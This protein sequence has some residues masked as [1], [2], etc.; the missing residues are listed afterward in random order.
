VRKKDGH[1]AAAAMTAKWLPIL[2]TGIGWFEIMIER[3]NDLEKSV[4]Q[5]G[6]AIA[7]DHEAVVVATA[8]CEPE[9]RPVSGARTY[10]R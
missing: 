8:V 3:L 2:G 1:Y 6:P 10:H 7:G 4:R 5:G 9:R